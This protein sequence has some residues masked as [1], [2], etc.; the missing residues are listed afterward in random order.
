MAGNSVDD[1][2]CFVERPSRYLGNEVNVVKKSHDD[3]DLRVALAF[4]DLYDI[5]TSHFGLQI[6]YHI[7]NRDARIV[8][9][10]VFA[11][12]LDMAQ[13]LETENRPLFALESGTPL[14]RFDIIGFSLLY[15]LNYTNVLFMLDLAGIP[16][17]AEDR[18]EGHPLII[19]GGPSTCNPEPVAEFFD[20]MVVGDGERVL[21]EMADAWLVWNESG[22]R[23]KED[24]LSNW[25][26]LEGVYIPSLFDVEWDRRG[27]QRLVPKKAGHCRISRA[28]EKDLD[29]APFPHRPVVPYGQPVHDRLR[30][31]IARGCSRGCRFCQAGFIYRPVRERS[32]STIERLTESALAATGY[33]DV[34]F[35]SLSTGDHS[36]LTPLMKNLVQTH[37]AT[38]VSISLPSMRAGTLTEEMMQLIRKVRK[39]GFTIAPE[40]GSERLRRVINKNLTEEEIVETVF[41]AFSLGWQVIKLYFMIGLPTETESDRD[42]IIELVERLRR[43]KSPDRKRAKINVSIATF[44]PKPH[45]PFQWEPQ[46]PEEEASAII[47][48]LK[49]R[50]RLPG[51]QFKWQNP[52]V[53]RLEG[54]FARGDRRLC[55]LLENA[56][57]SGC[58]Y[59]GWTDSFDYRLWLRACEEKGIDIHSYVHRRRALEEPLPWDVIDCGVDSP[60][61]INERE[62]AAAEEPTPDC[63]FEACSGC[64][65]CDFDHVLP[66]FASIDKKEGPAVAR[67][68]EEDGLSPESVVEIRLWI[69]YTKQRTARHFGHLEM[70]Q[71]FLRALRRAG[72]KMRFSSGFHP[73][74]LVSFHEALP[75]GIE[76]LEE[77]FYLT[78][79]AD[80]DTARLP[81]L[82]NRDLPG[83]LQV[84][85][86]RVVPISTG[87]GSETE[88]LYDIYR[89]DG[90][91]SPEM[92]SGFLAA[93][94]LPVSRWH[95]KKRCYVTV[96]AKSVIRSIHQEGPDH[97]ILRLS[98][99]A[100]KGMRPNDAVR[101][102]FGLGA[103]SIRKLRIVKRPV[104]DG[105]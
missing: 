82:L 7:L 21:L 69:R 97:V 22:T 28:I 94:S 12:G 19:A 64:G 6:L 70:V 2:R 47:A 62:K 25:A 18:K 91:F 17:R 57:R 92:L 102:V 4:P 84:L 65:V 39:T 61:L 24:L 60:F 72:V 27:Y 99:P 71:I 15:E 48:D 79:E 54:L 104:E 55:R 14:N 80:L 1:I 26:E 52:S 88:S 34:S 11:P 30:I 29:A 81:G 103:E 56:Y 49:G 68:K 31:E 100:G 53:S 35:L 73:K 85:D 77:S 33:D 36:C 90:S 86:C 9:E 89:T 5:G 23:K 16:F 40:A 42:A 20:A 38:P 43:L 83:G 76:S 75:V 13:K 46:L 59:D 93:E 41:R 96:D 51:V 50:L 67:V 78:A 10:R 58:R 32:A 105:E 101:A 37:R 45:T 44:V 8:A 98:R 74:P 66:R 3:V 63:R 95:G 87:P